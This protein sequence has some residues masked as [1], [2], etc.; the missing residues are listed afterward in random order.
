MSRP[1]FLN[2][3]Q[4]RFPVTAIVSILHRIS[5]VALFVAMPLLLLWVYCMIGS[6]YTF[7]LAQRLA[8]TSWIVCC[9]YL[10]VLALS[11]HAIAGVRHL[12]HD[13]VGCHSLVGARRTA[14]ATLIV[15][16]IWAVMLAYRIWFI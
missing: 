6:D 7:A 14:W 8:T 16:A 9:Y 10:V 3:L 1:I 4:I 5:G 2:L 11:Y 15:T 13:V 12:L